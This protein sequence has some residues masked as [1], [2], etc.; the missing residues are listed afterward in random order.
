MTLNASDSI[1]NETPGSN[2]ILTSIHARVEGVDWKKVHA[3]LD[4]TK[5]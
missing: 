3:E 1:A 5:A 2:Q 4:H